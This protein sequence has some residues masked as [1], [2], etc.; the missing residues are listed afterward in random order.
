[1]SY[2]QLGHGGFGT[3][4][5][6]SGNILARAGGQIAFAASSTGSGASAYAQL[7]HGGM[8]AQ[9]NNSG[10]ITVVTGADGT[11]TDTFDVNMDG[12]YD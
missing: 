11:F 12:M 4:G 8:G 10:N 1:E 9:G 5:D 3:Y 7:G 6:N 2:A